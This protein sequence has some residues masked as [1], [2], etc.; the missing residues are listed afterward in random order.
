[1]LITITAPLTRL[2]MWPCEDYICT[3]WLYH[4]INQLPYALHIL[5]PR[6]ENEFHSRIAQSEFARR[7]YNFLI[8]IFECTMLYCWL[9]NKYQGLQNADSFFNNL[10]YIL[11]QVPFKRDWRI[12]ALSQFIFSF[13]ISHQAR[14]LYH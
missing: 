5:W 4:A 13:C 6:W 14:W 9:P 8:S 7:A 1:M 11:R 10:L 3:S 12:A 2:P